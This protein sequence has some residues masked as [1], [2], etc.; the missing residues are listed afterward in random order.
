M[1]KYINYIAKITKA[2][3][4]SKLNPYT[5]GILLDTLKIF[6]YESRYENFITESYYLKLATQVDKLI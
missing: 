3:D 2:L 5:Q 1:K 4:T 6:R